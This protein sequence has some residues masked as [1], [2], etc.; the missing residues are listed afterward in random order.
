MRLKFGLHLL[1]LLSCVG[2]ICS[3]LVWL[4]SAEQEFLLR[5]IL[6]STPIQSNIVV[7][8]LPFLRVGTLQK[9]FEYSNHKSHTLYRIQ[10]V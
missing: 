8:V 4:F 9:K 2:I 6:Y 7:K 1:S 10:T 3:G 5:N